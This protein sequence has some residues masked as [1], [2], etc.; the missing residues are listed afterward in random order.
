MG[1]GASSVGCERDAQVPSPASSPK[2]KYNECDGLTPSTNSDTT[3]GKS[4]TWGKVN[5]LDVCTKGDEAFKPTSL[6]VSLAFLERFASELDPRLTTLEVVETIIQPRTSEKA[7]SY[8]ELLSETEVGVPA[9]YVCHS[10][11]ASFRA[12]VDFIKQ[13][14]GLT[15]GVDH[16]LVFV[17]LDIFATNYHR[18]SVANQVQEI[19]RVLATVGMTL[20]CLD[21]A[22]SL[23]NGMWNLLEIFLAI[24]RNGQPSLKVA[25]TEHPTDKLHSRL[26]SLRLERSEASVLREE[27]L[28]YVL[29]LADAPRLDRIVTKAILASAFSTATWLMGQE[30][31]DA[32]GVVRLCSNNAEM[33]AACQLYVQSETVWRHCLQVRTTAN[34]PD[35][36][37]TALITNNLAFVLAMQQK[38]EEAEPFCRQALDLR[39]RLFGR[40]HQDTASSLN[41]LAGLLHLKGK[42]I[43]AEKLYR[44]VVDLRAAIH[45]PE[46][47]QTAS[48]LFEL[49]SVYSTQGKALEA[50]TLLRTSLRVRENSFGPA[51]PSTKAAVSALNAVLDSQGKRSGLRG[52]DPNSGSSSGPGS[53][54]DSC[55]LHSSGEIVT[56]P[57][58]KRKLPPLPS[59]A[60]VAAGALTVVQEAPPEGLS[61]AA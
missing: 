29:S 60:T 33:L 38:M 21:G 54:Y 2:A 36:A 42:H 13:Y 27:L 34:L 43:E 6:A 45:G 39:L 55:S 15:T 52:S 10:M 11:T 49:A 28:A 8:V 17:F 32:E 1:C 48:S 44:E 23:L 14:T 12:T 26:L 59:T 46:H 56:P 25:L 20:V 16:T 40:S 4:G 61:A 53:P 18:L 37:E 24:T 35:S 50:E 7:C 22:G 3:E 41:A 58:D 9:I 30:V 31:C 47:P 51:H 57:N 19:E 5:P